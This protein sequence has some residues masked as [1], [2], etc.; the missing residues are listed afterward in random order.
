M[1]F[2]K[3]N[4]CFVTVCN[5]ADD[6]KMVLKASE[7]IGKGK[8]VLVIGDAGVYDVQEIKEAIK[9]LEEFEASAAT[10]ED[11]AMSGIHMP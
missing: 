6:S 3:E 9:T 7:S 8:A 5:V 4:V 11:P 10:P 1:S 2:K